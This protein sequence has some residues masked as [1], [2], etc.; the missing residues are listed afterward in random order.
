MSILLDVSDLKTQYNTE[1]GIVKAVDGVS[2]Q[3]YKNEIVGFV[4]ESGCGKS[5]TML[6]LM[7]L[8]PSPPGEIVSG[9]A[10]LDGTDLLKLKENE[11]CDI[12][13][14]RISMVFQEPMTSLNPTMKIGKQLTEMITR[15]KKVSKA[16][17]RSHAIECLEKVGITNAAER[18]NSY[19]HEF[20]GGMRQRVMIAMAAACNPSIIIADEPTTALDVTTQSQV[21]E[22]LKNMVTE[23][24]DTSLIIVTHNLAIIARYANRIYVMYGG[25]VI[26]SGTA[27]DVF[28]HPMHPYTKGLLRSVP[29]LDEA[30][31]DK[32]LEPIDGFPPNL[33]ALP[34]YCSFEP[35]CNACKE[36]CKEKGI[37]VLRDMGNSH[38]V[39]CHQYEE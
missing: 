13:G 33:A 24:K 22:M 29:R 21:L 32:R 23:L 4:G 8:I 30:M 36:H 37:P 10:V 15:H 26:E 12:R 34:S 1:S 9:S 19:P 20:S 2:F 14:A 3:I 25:K 28:A 5:A 7:Q 17:A 31:S 11:I 35:R 38:F 6:S 18:M 16:E 27:R 39:A